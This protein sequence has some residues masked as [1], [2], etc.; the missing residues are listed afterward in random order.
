MS[1]TTVQA[2]KD[3]IGFAGW[4]SSITDP[5]IQTY[6]DLAEEEIEFIYKTK[7]GNVEQS[8]TASTGGTT[9][10]TDATKT[11]VADAYVD[12]VLWIYAGTG[13]GQYR[14]I[15]TNSTTVLTVSPAFSP[16]TDITS[17]YR[18]VK[19]GYKNQDVTGTGRDIQFLDYQ[20]LINLNSLT[21]D[22]TNITISTVYQWKNAGKIGLSNSSEASS[23]TD[24]YP[25]KINVKYVYGVYPI[26]KTIVRLCTLFAGIRASAAQMGASYSSFNSISMP[27]GFSG[28]KGDQVTKLKAVADSLQSEARDIVYG[29]PNNPLSLMG[30]YRPFINLG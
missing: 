25:F 13:S 29:D 5:N 20:P 27:G 28:S 30:V 12:Y 1:Y 17:K 3:A 2:V 22:T 15:T 26:P 21:V 19:L 14:P 11:F 18:V 16:A 4:N 6:I 23:F 10:L 8:G 24:A 9:T 7:F